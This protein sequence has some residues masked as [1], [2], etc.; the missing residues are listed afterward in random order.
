MILLLNRNHFLIAKKVSNMKKILFFLAFV[1]SLLSFSSCLEE[2]PT[3]SCNKS[4]DTWVKENLPTIQKMTR[5]DWLRTDSTVNIAIYRAFTPQQRLK[6]WQEKFREVKQLNWSKEELS[7][8]K[9]VEDFINT[10][11]EYFEGQLSD[12][13]LDSLELFSYQ[14]QEY[15][16]TK[17]GWSKDICKAL[18]AMGNKVKN[19]KGELSAVTTSYSNARI[20]RVENCDCS[21]YSDWCNNGWYC[22]ETNCDETF[23]G[24]GFLLLHNCT[25]NCH[26]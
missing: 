18:V 20:T 14:W 21:V 15:A 9:K 1:V 13:Q 25:G 26:W 4:V 23:M 10:H 8:I 11:K 2:E 3:Y 22:K 17:L 6:F 19:T 12:E 5:A 16:T 24:C 7:H